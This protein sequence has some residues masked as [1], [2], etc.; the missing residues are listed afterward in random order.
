MSEL[1]EHLKTK[2][3]VTDLETRMKNLE[4]ELLQFSDEKEKIEKTKESF[5][6]QL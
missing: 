1:N 2:S 4:E 5:E 3:Q 6:R